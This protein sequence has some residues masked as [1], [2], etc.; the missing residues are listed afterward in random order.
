MKYLLLPMVFALLACEPTV[1]APPCGPTTCF[2]CCDSTTGQCVAGT[3]TSACGNGGYVCT[4]CS[5]SQ[6]CSGGQCSSGGTTCGNCSGCC[7]GSTCVINT[8]ER[9]CGTTGSACQAC[10]P[11][12]I[13]ANGICAS[14][15]CSSATCLSGCC[16]NGSCVE[17]ANQT[18]TICG[19]GGSACSP[20][21]PNQQCQSGSCAAVACNA[22]TCSDGCCDATGTCVRPG[23][24]QAACGSGGG[25][26]DVCEADETCDTG[27]CHPTTQEC[28]PATCGD[29]CCNAQGCQPG[30][31][32]GACGT[33][34]GTCNECGSSQACDAT[35]KKC[36]CTTTSCPGC[37]EGDS[38]L[39]GTDATAC[40]V[41]G[42]SCSQ[43]TGD[44]TCSLGVCKVECTLLSCR[45]G[46]C[47]NNTCVEDGG[48]NANACGL[49]GASCTNC[50]TSGQTCSNGTCNDASKCNATTCAYGCCKDGVC[51]KPASAASACGFLANNCFSCD[52]TYETCIG[53]GDYPAEDFW[54]APKASSI[55][56]V[57]L[58]KVILD[59]SVSWDT[60]LAD[61]KPDVFVEFSVG[62]N[63]NTSKTIDNSY[64]PDFEG[65][66]LV[67]VPASDLWTA[68]YVTFEIRDSDFFGSQVVASCSE[69]IYSNELKAGKLELSECKDGG[70]NA[71]S[72]LKF[73]EF[74]FTLKSP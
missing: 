62:N 2:G 29:G 32:Q 42:A 40:G 48:T 59:S 27:A 14:A 31:V 41:S 15:G 60:G 33:G 17:L 23:S 56:S 55:W 20:C 7:S 39:L 10:D 9:F 63:K 3:V 72:N 52:A 8:S 36:T 45:S 1:T 30:N 22:T 74:R 57:T 5:G 47:Q 67:S 11:G 37:C 50:S 16:Y 58:H 13:C 54:C 69:T 68:G 26:C 51:A 71:Q 24:S 35:A 70:G 46:C 44:E 64:T 53:W 34:G 12:E 73:I 38:C 61:P 19:T 49:N 28:G 6:T 65:E 18:T 21:Q 66:F 25:Q 4:A 43:C